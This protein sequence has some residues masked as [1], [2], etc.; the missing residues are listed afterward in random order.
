MSAVGEVHQVFMILVALAAQCGVKLAHFQFAHNGLPHIAWHVAVIDNADGFAVLSA[1]HPQGD[2]FH[3]A[4]VGV[5]INFHLRIF[6]KLE[7]ECPVVVFGKSDK[8]EWQAEAYHVIKIHDVIEAIGPGY[9][10]ESPVDLVG[11]FD[12]SI[13]GIVVVLLGFLYQQVYTIVF[14]RGEILQFVEP[15][16]VGRAIELV[17]EEIA[18]PHPLLI[19]ELGLIEQSDVVAFQ[20]FEYFLGSLKIL[21]VILLVKS[22]N[23]LDGPLD[24]MTHTLGDI[25][26]FGNAVERCYPNT[27]ELIEIAGVYAEERQSFKK[28]N[29][30]LLC[31][32]QDTIVEIHPADIPFHIHAFQLSVVCHNIFVGSNNSVIREG[33]TYSAIPP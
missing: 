4:V 12:N 16:G 24:V 19:I 25:R 23:G 13:F 18:E 6:G 29:L 27:K 5:V 17:I 22:A 33:T 32:L 28:G 31:L 3:G 7:T 26:T 30:R 10:D 11:H 15:D 9:L 8:D 14:Q 1:A 20:F 21:L 2:T